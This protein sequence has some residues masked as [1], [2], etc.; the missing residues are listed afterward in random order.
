[1]TP[2]LLL[3]AHMPVSGGLPR[4][5]ERIRSLQG[6]ALQIFTRNQRQ[7]REPELTDQAV[8]D[9]AAA[10]KAWGG[11]PVLVH[12]GY[13]PNL[14]SPDPKLRQRSIQSVAA[15]L[16][17]CARLDVPW[18]VTHPGSYKAGSRAEGA[19]RYAKGLDSVLEESENETVT[20]LLENTA[21]QGTNL[22]ASFGELAEI[23][24]AS[25]HPHRLGLCLDTCHAFAA[26]YDLRSPG[27]LE[28]TLAELDAALG[29]D[30]LQ[31]LHLNDSKHPLGSRK[32][33]HEH[34]GEGF[35]GQA[36]F[37]AILA[38]PRLAGLPMVIET[39]KGGG[40]DLLEPDRR[41]LERL[42]RLVRR[43]D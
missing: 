19:A 35:V 10:R 23:L 11:Y 37:A 17:R 9:F 28:A 18:L 2:L 14:A 24:A 1:M 39:P 3:G 20:I 12:D 33:R 43:W 42:R 30:R 25:R 13:L 4:A 38:H 7:W 34:I 5:V 27:A 22:G 41:N 36:G 31:A 8:R 40:A 21:G 26:G 6:T 29:L 15:E 16:R 32:D